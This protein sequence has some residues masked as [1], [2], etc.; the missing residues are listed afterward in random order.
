MIIALMVPY[1]AKL[2]DNAVGELLDAAGKRLS[3]LPLPMGTR[4]MSKDGTKAYLC[5]NAVL[6]RCKFGKGCKSKKNHPGKG[7]LTNDFANAVA[8][9]LKPAVDHIVATKESPPK[10]PKT[11]GGVI[12]IE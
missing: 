4:F 2:G 6:G 3:D 11:E 5:W 12:S 1:I 7:E 10:K 9:M 8:A